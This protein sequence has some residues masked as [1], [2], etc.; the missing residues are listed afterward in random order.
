MTKREMIETI[1]WHIKRSIKNTKDEEICYRCRYNEYRTAL[2]LACVMYYIRLI[3]KKNWL[4]LMN[5]IF[6][7]VPTELK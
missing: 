4:W 7:N 2:D 1:I 6:D 5:I 3:N